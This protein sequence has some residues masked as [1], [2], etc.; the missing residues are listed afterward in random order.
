MSDNILRIQVE[1]ESLGYKTCL[2]DSPYG[3]VVAFSYKVEV[4][5]HAGKTVTLGISMQGDEAYPEYPPHWIHIMPSIN[6]GR[7]G[8][9]Y[10][11]EKGREWIAMSRIP[12]PLWDELPTKHMS[13]Y[14]NEHLR[15][16]W[17][18]M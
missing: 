9:I 16:F 13:H 14:L 8:N 5:P 10:R 18:N 6:D 11:D 3:R 1:L 12:G 17:N 4:G 7:G 15:R 2:L